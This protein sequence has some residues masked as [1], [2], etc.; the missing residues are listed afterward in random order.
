MKNLSNDRVVWGQEIVYDVPCHVPA[1]LGHWVSRDLVKCYF[2][3]VWASLIAQLV[4]NPPG[5]QEAL[6]RFLDWED[7]LEKDRLPTPVFLGFPCGSAGN[8]SDCN[9]GDLGSIPELGRSPGE[10]KGYPFQY[11]GLENSRDYIVHGVAKSQTGL[12]DFHFTSLHTCK[13]HS[14]AEMIH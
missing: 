9:V 4:K 8:E 5:M 12:R 2:E 10:G 1:W 6:V 3:Y 13:L 7:H 14:E 11:S